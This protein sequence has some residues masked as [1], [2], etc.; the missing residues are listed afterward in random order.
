MKLNKFLILGVLVSLAFSARSFSG[1]TTILKGD[2]LQ[3]KPTLTILN[4]GGTLALPSTTDTLVGKAT[5][6]TL[7]NKSIDASTN[8]LTN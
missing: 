4:G 5:T 8:T 6:D 7:T 2:Q 3:G 1:A